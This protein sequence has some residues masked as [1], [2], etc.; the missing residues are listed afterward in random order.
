MDSNV[1]YVENIKQFYPVPGADVV[2]L[3]FARRKNYRSKRRVSRNGNNIVR[4]NNASHIEKR[5]RGKYNFVIILY[6]VDKIEQTAELLH[7]GRQGL[8][9]SKGIMDSHDIPA[10]APACRFKNTYG[11]LNPRALRISMLYTIISFNV[12][13]RYFVWNFK[14]TFSN[15]IQNILPIHWKMYILYTYKI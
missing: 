3:C 14:G 6:I 12:W 13:V 15:S 7:R 8:V 2:V 5:W 11:L 1:S 4:T 9:Y 10:S